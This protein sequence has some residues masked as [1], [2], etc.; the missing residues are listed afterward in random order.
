MAYEF[1]CTITGSKSGKFKG[2]DTPPEHKDKIRGLVFRY[3]LTS[4]RDMVT[5]HASGK[6]QH[7]PIAILKEVGPSSPQVL[8]SA[9]N[10]EVLTS[11]LFEFIKVSQAGGKASVYYT[12]K[13]TNA[14][15]CNLEQFSPHAGTGGTPLKG[16]H[17]RVEIGSAPLRGEHEYEWVSFTFEKIEVTNVDAK[18]SFSDTWH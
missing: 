6:R 5:G 15:I 12:V 9:A 11:V 10:N 16:G 2:D 7:H 18:T 17:E 1:Y 14:T 13:L 8:Q 3:G 4:P